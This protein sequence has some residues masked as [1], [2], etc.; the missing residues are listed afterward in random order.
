MAVEAWWPCSARVIPPS[1]RLPCAGMVR[2]K[3]RDS[4]RRPEV[5]ARGMRG[6]AGVRAL[7]CYELQEVDMHCAWSVDHRFLSVSPVPAG[8]VV[9]GLPSGRAGDLVAPLIGKFGELIGLCGWVVA[10]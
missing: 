9:P 4:A 8:P 2:R 10:Q 3:E 1:E 6:R 7:G 5:D